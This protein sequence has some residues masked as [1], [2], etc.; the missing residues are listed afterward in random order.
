MVVGALHPRE[1]AGLPNTANT[2]CTSIAGA[3]ARR[4][5]CT[6]STRRERRYWWT[7]AGDKLEV[8]NGLTGQS[9]ALDQFV[10]ILGASEL[11]YVEAHESQ[12]EQDWIRAN[13]GAFR[14]FGGVTSALIPDNLK[15]AV[16]GSDPYRRG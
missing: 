5:R 8:I 2:A 15:T 9:W 14:Y 11:T 6:S 4:C 10:A 12:N 3:E 7:R 13:E 1:P 16:I